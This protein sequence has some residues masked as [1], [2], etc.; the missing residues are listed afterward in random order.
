MSNEQGN[1][2]YK[3]WG[4]DWAGAFVQKLVL[5]NEKER[6]IGRKQERRKE[7]KEAG[8]KKIKEK[9]GRNKGRRGA[10]EEE[11]NEE[12]RVKERKKHDQVMVNK[13]ASL[14]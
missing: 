12:G 8:T 13:C 1:K 5:M 14:D 4:A 2:P 6:R 3:L 9:E 7:G 10:Q 11:R